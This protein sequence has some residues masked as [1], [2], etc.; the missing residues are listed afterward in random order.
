MPDQPSALAARAALASAAPARVLRLSAASAKVMEQWNYTTVICSSDFLAAGG[1]HLER[2]TTRRDCSPTSAHHAP[3]RRLSAKLVAALG[4]P[5]ETCAIGS[6]HVEIRRLT[7]VAREL[8]SAIP[9]EPKAGSFRRLETSELR[10]TRDGGGRERAALLDRLNVDAQ[11]CG[12]SLTLIVDGAADC[13]EV[14][15]SRDGQVN[16]PALCFV[17]RPALE[18]AGQLAWLLDDAIDAASRARRYLVWRFADLRQQRLLLE[19]FRPLNVDRAQAVSELDDLENALLDAV[20]A[21]KWSAR[22]TSVGR[23]GFEAAAL[24]DPDAKRMPMPGYNELVRLVSSTPSVYGLLSASVH[25]ARFGMHYGLEVDG[26][27]DRAGQHDAK[28]GGFGIDT[29]VLIG[30]AALAIDRTCRLLAGWNGVDAQVL[31]H[32]VKA[33]MRKAGIL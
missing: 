33:L 25:G 20:A 15:S 29:N 27:P 12:G 31:H 26:R 11:V 9:A 23:K 24:L 32:E 19:Q 8:I 17:V 30:L 2:P 21:A 6:A 18:V 4:P 1:R 28:L 16:Q 22:A 10:A 13:L 7:R 5:G 3:Q 14:A